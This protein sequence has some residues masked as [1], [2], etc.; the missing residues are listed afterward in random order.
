MGAFLQVD[1]KKSLS[2]MPVNTG[3]SLVLTISEPVILVTNQLFLYAASYYFLLSCY[4]QVFHLCT[5]WE[6]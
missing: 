1:F 2:K 4:E 6:L 3:K 5:D